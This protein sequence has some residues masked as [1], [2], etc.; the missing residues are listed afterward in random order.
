MSNG[1]Y[2]IKE[3]NHNQNLIIEPNPEYKGDRAAQNDGIE[4]T[5]YADSSA[6]YMDLLAN[7]LD[8]LEAIPSSAFGSYEQDLGDRQETK[9]AATYL[10][11]SIHME[12]PHFSGEELSLIHI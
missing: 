3:W 11:M 12:T 5:F 1:P 9:P 2:K 4:F 10:E 6:A 8:V 7:N